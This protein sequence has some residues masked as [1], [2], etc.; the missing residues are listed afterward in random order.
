MTESSAPAHVEPVATA[1]VVQNPAT[2][3]FNVVVVVPDQIPIRMVNAS[4]LEDYEFHIYVASLFFGATTGFLTPTIQELRAGSPLA[5]PFLAMTV[6]LGVAFA[7][8]FLMA[9]SKRKALKAGGKEI[10]L[11]T[12]SASV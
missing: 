8:T 10:K 9:R 6:I 2:D 1:P 4:V 11:R 5:L 7:A 3:T 12:T